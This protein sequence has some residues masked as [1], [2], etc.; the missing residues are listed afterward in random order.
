M[1]SAGW[2]KARHDLR[3]RIEQTADVLVARVDAAARAN[4][5]R[6][7]TPLAVTDIGLEMNDFIGTQTE[8]PHQVGMRAEAPVSNADAELG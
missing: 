4:G 8:K 5:A 1:V 7:R 3:E 6:H 2:L